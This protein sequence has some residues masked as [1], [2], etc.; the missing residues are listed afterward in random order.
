MDPSKDTWTETD[1]LEW[2][3]KQRFQR[4]YAEQ[5]LAR[6][7]KLKEVG[8][9]LKVRSYGKLSLQARNELAIEGAV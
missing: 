1:K 5:V 8:D 7:E 4:N 9:P 3:A 2:L 6:I